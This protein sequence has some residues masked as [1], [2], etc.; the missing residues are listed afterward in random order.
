MN[1]VRNAVVA[2][3]YAYVEGGASKVAISTAVL[4][5]RNTDLRVFFIGGCGEAAQELRDSGADCILLGLP[6]L[7]QNPSKADA[8]LHGIYNREVYRKVRELLQALDPAETVLHVHTW[9]KVLTSAVFRAAH[10][11][12]IRVFLTVHD[13]FLACP[14]GGCYDYV[15]RRICDLRP[16]SARCVCRNCDSRNYIY[17]IWRCLR[18]Q[19]QNRVLKRID[20][21][22]IF[23][24]DFQREKLHARG[25]RA[26]KEY[27]L[28]NVIRTGER[29]R[30]K[31]EE[32]ELFLMA[33]RLA[34]EKGADLFCEAVTRAGVPAAAVG[35]GPLKEQLEKMYPEISFPG[36]LPPEE[37]RQWGDR[38][39]CF[40]F[41][42]VW[43]EGSPLSVPE[44]QACGIPCIVTDCSAATD[45]VENG[46]NGLTVRADAREMEYA[47]RQFAED[48]PVKEM[49]LAAYEMF[50]EEGCSEEQYV[51][52][53]REIYEEDFPGCPE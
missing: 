10:D 2:C 15:G 17:K 44:M 1:K 9:T 33:G 7:L 24:S 30:V 28:R 39:R 13:Y 16:M 14:N 46:K 29:H 27:Y 3:D 48:A 12:G 52:R 21:R 22:Y 31:A 37:V 26:R 8:F 38:A 47:I 18:Q 36:W 11:C 50:D 23:I 41:P 35:D 32:N 19:K 40:V 20:V 6:D 5:S 34:P 25:V 51:K 4:L 43:Y 45:T 42:S 49:S 53:L